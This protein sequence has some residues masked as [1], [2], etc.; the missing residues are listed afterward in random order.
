MSQLHTPPINQPTK[1]AVTSRLYG[2]NSSGAG[3]GSHLYGVLGL[4]SSKVL[5]P[6]KQKNIN[7][8]L[9][10]LSELFYTYCVKGCQRCQFSTFCITSK[11]PATGFVPEKVQEFFLFI[12]PDIYLCLTIAWEE[13][14]DNKLCIWIGSFLT[15][16]VSVY[17]IVLPQWPRLF[18]IPTPILAEIPREMCMHSA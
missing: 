10:I 6:W 13:Q 15:G 14:G 2:E 7:I 16:L 11:V 12:I 9:S 5:A 18:A 4:L 8:D 1:P 17:R 3:C